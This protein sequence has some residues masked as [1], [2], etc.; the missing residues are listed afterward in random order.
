M[1][2]VTVRELRNHGGRVLQRVTKGE[3][4]TV[5]M[6]GRAVAELRPL[7][8]KAV[9]AATLLSRWRGLPQVDAAALRADL[10]RV[11]DMSI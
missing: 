2:D 5:T 4:L 3:S 6:D 8:G 9:S 1:A 7:P 10:D 11:L